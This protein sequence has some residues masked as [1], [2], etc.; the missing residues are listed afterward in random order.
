MLINFSVSILC[1]DFRN[2]A[3]PLHDD[4]KTVQGD[5]IQLAAYA[6]VQSLSSV[7][8]K[9]MPF[10][11]RSVRPLILYLTTESN[12]LPVNCFPPVYISGRP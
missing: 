4:I 2:V 6:V 12:R 7:T 5:F 9:L 11:L 10:T 8:H 1:E 3:V